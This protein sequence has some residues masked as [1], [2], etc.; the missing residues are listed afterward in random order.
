METMH[1]YA[2]RLLLHTSTAQAVLFKSIRHQIVF[3][4]PGAFSQPLRKHNANQQLRICIA[5]MV[6]QLTGLAKKQVPC[7]DILQIEIIDRGQ[8]CLCA[9]QS[10]AKKSLLLHTD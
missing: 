7:A 8:A 6:Q 1:L 10:F 5:L 3:G 9:E 4:I 2:T